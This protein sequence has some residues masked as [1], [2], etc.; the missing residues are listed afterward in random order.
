MELQ[1]PQ[2]TE[3]LVD[4][5]LVTQAE[6]QDWLVSYLAELLE[7]ESD[8]VDVTIPFDRY[9]LDSS[10][11]MGLIGDI[12]DCINLNLKPTTLYNY[13]TIEAL[14]EYLAQLADIRE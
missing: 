7:I 14:T 10:A 12:Q 1:S 11:A 2:L 8:E 6:I 4:K 9:G 13:P 5:Q 3:S